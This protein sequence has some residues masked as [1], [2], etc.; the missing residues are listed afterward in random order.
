MPIEPVD[1][2]D[3]PEFQSL[4]TGGKKKYPW[5]TTAPG[6]GFKFDAGVTLS[7]ARSQVAN[8][9]RGSDRQFIVRLDMQENIWCIRIDGLP[10]AEREAW[11]MKRQRKLA[12]A[13]ISA[14]EFAEMNETGPYVGA[15]S[16]SRGQ[17]EREEFLIYPEEPKI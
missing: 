17:G 1:M 12:S 13:N 4:G 7:G 5:L 14:D 15:S 8:Y 2:Q 6:Q 9:M 3:M 10:L 16:P 11:R